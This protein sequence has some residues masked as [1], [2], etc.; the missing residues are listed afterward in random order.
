MGS[1]IN[2]VFGSWLDSNQMKRELMS[3]KA[4]LFAI[5]IFCFIGIIS[6]VIAIIWFVCMLVNL[7]IESLNISGINYLLS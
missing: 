2:S 7:L 5:L 6:V 4:L 1:G 3:V